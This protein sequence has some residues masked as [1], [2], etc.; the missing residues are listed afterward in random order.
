MPDERDNPTEKTSPDLQMLERKLATILSADVAEYSRL[1]GEDEEGTL[2]AFRG[3]KQVFES[4]VTMHRGRIFN[5]AGDAILAEFQSAV[6][7]VRCAT[8]I[9][10]ALRTRND[11]LPPNRQVRFR[12]GIN[13]GDVMVQGQDLMGDGVNVAAR[14]QT[15]AEPGGV[16]ISGSVH[17]QIR[18]K[19]SLSFHSLGEK[20]F[21][22]IQQPVRTFAVSETEVDAGDVLPTAVAVPP[23]AA[24]K[25]GS[26]AKW[27]VA[28]LVLLLAG[29]GFWAYSAMHG[30]K[31]E[32]MAAVTPPP[33]TPPNTAGSAVPP[34][35]PP[36]AAPANPPAPGAP[37]N[38]AASP[39]AATPAAVGGAAIPASHPHAAH[40]AS[41]DGTYAG[42]ICFAASPK[43]P[44]RCFRVEGTITGRKISAQWTMGRERVVA[45]L[46]NGDVAN[47]GAVTIEMEMHKRTADGERLA[48]IDVVGTLQDGVIEAKGSFRNGRGATLN[49]RKN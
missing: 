42:P 8:D 10:A 37:P 6:E 30:S 21:K 14:I 24:P 15:A 13:L 19:L 27:L 47:S 11:Q 3:H 34:T 31:P 16:C 25:D 23:I 1:M 26:L 35:Q 2:R 41:I 40:L 20:S 38:S 36:T 29:G 17:D 48:T 33:A 12:I 7:A 22:N 45:M 44:N 32:N 9:Q 46:L 49:W 28:A 5:T 4:L 39:A 43:E 18:N